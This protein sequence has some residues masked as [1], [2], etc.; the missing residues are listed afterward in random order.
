MSKAQVSRSLRLARNAR[1]VV[2]CWRIRRGIASCIWKPILLTRFKRVK[3]CPGAQ[4]AVEKLVSPVRF[5]GAAQA[6]QG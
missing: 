3:A 1:L 5:T 4:A 6:I 2:V